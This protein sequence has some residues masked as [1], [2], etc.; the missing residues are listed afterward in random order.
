MIIGQKIA[1]IF[2]GHSSAQLFAQIL[3]PTYKYDELSA[4]KL[5]QSQGSTGDC[6]MYVRENFNVWQ[7]HVSLLA[8][9][10]S[11][12]FHCA[13]GPYTTCTKRLANIS[14]CGRHVSVLAPD[15][16]LY[17]S[18]CGRRVHYFA[19]SDPLIFKSA[20]G[21]CR[22]LQSVIRLHFSARQAS[23]SSTIRWLT[24]R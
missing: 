7:A 4:R 3:W 5:T 2:F 8:L 23:I 21:V 18:L 9:G 14:E 10:D 24:N 15:D 13:A 6:V 22:F 19:P 20:T 1:D 17:I 12:T 11:L 16:S